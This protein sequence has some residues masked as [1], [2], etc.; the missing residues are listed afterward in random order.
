MTG[1]DTLANKVDKACLDQVEAWV[2]GNRI[3]Q[4]FDTIVLRAENNTAEVFLTDPPVIAKCV[5]Q[6][7][8][9]GETVRVRLLSADADLR[10]VTF[11]VI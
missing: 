9:E 6:N 4:E 2:L 8:P 7:L 10:K 1:S 3:G 11:E 5:G